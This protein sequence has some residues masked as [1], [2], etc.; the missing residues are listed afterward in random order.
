[1][2]FNKVTKAEM[3]SAFLKLQAENAQLK[4]DLTS[5]VQLANYFQSNLQVIENLLHSA[6]FLNQEGKFFK[7][8]AWVLTNFSKIRTLIED[9]F[10]T[11][12]L[13]KQRVTELQEQAKAAS[14]NGTTM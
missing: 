8:L 6:P 13:W 12:R 1:M 7:K 3:Q 14:S 5:V 9:I 2:D 11:I 4:T 10:A